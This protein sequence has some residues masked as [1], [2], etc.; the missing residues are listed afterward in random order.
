MRRELSK[1]I[2]A[3]HVLRHATF[4]WWMDANGTDNNN[5]KRFPAAKIMRTHGNT[6]QSGR[7]YAERFLRFTIN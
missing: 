6:N 7:N 3:W 2:M 1:F 4:H 5:E